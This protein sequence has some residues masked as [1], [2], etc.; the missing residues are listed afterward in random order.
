MTDCTE[1]KSKFLPLAAALEYRLVPPPP[2]PPHLFREV[3]EAHRVAARL[4]ADEL[5][6]RLNEEGGVG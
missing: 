3:H 6:L 1:G 4:T 2:P 5:A